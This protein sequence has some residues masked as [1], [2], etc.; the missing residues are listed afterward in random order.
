MNIPRPSRDRISVIRAVM[1]D[2]VD[3]DCLTDYEMAWLEDQA[4]EQI[5]AKLAE[6]NDMVFSGNDSNLFH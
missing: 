4:M 6:T 2:E 5:I 1:M 3:P